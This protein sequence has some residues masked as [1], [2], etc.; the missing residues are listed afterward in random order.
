MRGH[1]NIILEPNYVAETPG[2]L[3][4]V[5]DPAAEPITTEEAAELAA[6]EAADHPQNML[7]SFTGIEEKIVDGI[8]AGRA[9]KGHYFSLHPSVKGTVLPGQTVNEVKH[10]IGLTCTIN[11]N[12]K[13]LL[14][15]VKLTVKGQKNADDF[16]KITN[17]E[18]AET[19]RTDGFITPG[20]ELYIHGEKIKIA[21]EQ[22]DNGKIVEEGI[23][24]FFVPDDGTAQIPAKRIRLNQP[25]FLSVK[26]PNNL[27]NNT[28][29]TLK[30]T[31]R[32]TGSYLLN[33]PRTVIYSK[34]LFTV[35]TPTT[36]MNKSELNKNKTK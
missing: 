4:S 24:V 30:I 5:F 22:D 31:T 34:K 23:G 27:D 20:D 16:A 7:A 29:Y 10:K 9:Y 8:L 15:N 19:E 18:D 33:K 28:K 12:F 26:M 36:D 17:V 21:G 3:K 32:F 13:T 2:A 1:W 14:N 25:S 35:D 11:N 6:K